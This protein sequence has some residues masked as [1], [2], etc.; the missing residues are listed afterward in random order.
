M[1]LE[2]STRSRCSFRDH[3]EFGF[4]HDDRSESENLKA[5]EC[6]DLGDFINTA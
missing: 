4:Y 1:S 5:V 6:P 3:K 2:G